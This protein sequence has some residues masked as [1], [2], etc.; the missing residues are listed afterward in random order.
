MS[1]VSRGVLGDVIHSLAPAFVGKA[2]QRE[3]NNVSQALRYLNSTTRPR[4]VLVLDNAVT[5]PAYRDVLLHLVQYAR[6]GGTVIFCGRFSCDSLYD[7]ITLMFKSAWG[8][9]WTPCAYTNVDVAVNA[10][11]KLLDKNH[12]VKT[13][14]SKATYL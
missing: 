14:C 2:A 1:F 10:S 3:V 12:L 6:S 5:L 4:A 13:Y 9:P 7:D 8:L 11:M